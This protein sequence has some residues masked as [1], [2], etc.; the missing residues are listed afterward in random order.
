[1]IAAKGRSLI[2]APIS[3]KPIQASPPGIVVTVFPDTDRPLFLLP[4]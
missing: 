4:A 3:F 1:M 2:L